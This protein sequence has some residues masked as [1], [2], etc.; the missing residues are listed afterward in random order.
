M[1]RFTTA[2]VAEGERLAETPRPSRGRKS[3]Q[4]GR[5]ADTQPILWPC[6]ISRVYRPEES[7]SVP[8][9]RSAKVIQ[10]TRAPAKGFPFRWS[11]TVPVMRMPPLTRRVMPEVEAPSA[12]CTSRP[13][14]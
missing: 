4:P 12:S 3:D 10:Y 7:L 8:A 13:A 2:R 1:E 6:G 14:A 11:E 5:T 9:I